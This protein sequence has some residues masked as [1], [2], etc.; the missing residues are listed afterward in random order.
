M[1]AFGLGSAWKLVSKVQSSGAPPLQQLA[2]LG[3]AGWAL[4]TGQVQL[5]ALLIFGGQLV[6]SAVS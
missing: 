4:Y 2:F 3:L 1:A 6:A 5:A